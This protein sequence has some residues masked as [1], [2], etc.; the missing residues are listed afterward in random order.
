MVYTR[1]CLVNC[2]YYRPLTKLRKGNVF[3]S[4]CQE[5]CP[6]GEEVY[7]PLRWIPPRQT[8]P[9]RPRQR[10]PPW[11]LPLRRSLQRT[12]RILLECILV[13][14]GKYR[15]DS[16]RTTV[17]EPHSFFLKTEQ[18]VV[19]ATVMLSCDCSG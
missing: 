9:P 12:V 7:T 5:F 11:H 16:M 13:Y 19:F 14:K 15:I 18:K 2:G 17:V 6:G 10:D 3:T 8:D 4:V 1:S